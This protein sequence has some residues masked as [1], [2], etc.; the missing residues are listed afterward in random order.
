MDKYTSELGGETEVEDDGDFTVTFSVR[1]PA[2]ADDD[3]D[4]R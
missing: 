2:P 3:T 1:M 4:E